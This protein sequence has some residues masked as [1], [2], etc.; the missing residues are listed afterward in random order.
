MKSDGY[1]KTSLKKRFLFSGFFANLY[2]FFAFHIYLLLSIL[3]AALSIAVILFFAEM[4][5]PKYV[6]LF[7]YSMSDKVFSELVADHKYHEAIA[8]MDTKKDMIEESDESYRYRQELADCYIHTGDYPKALEQYRLLRQEIDQKFKEEPP[9][10][11]TQ[12]QLKNFKD[13]IDACFLKEEFRIYLKMG[14]LPNIRK[15][16]GLIT[17]RYKDVDWDNLF[18]Y[19]SEE[20]QEKLSQAL[21]GRSFE[22]GFQLELIQGKYLTDPTAGIEQMEKYAIDVANSKDFNQVYKLRLFNELL[23][24][25]LEQNDTI[26]ARYYLEYALQIVDS[27]EYNS[28]IYPQLGE[29]SDYC[30]QL[31]DIADGK[32]LL[33]KYLSYVDDT[34]DESDI[35][36][37]LAHA[38]EFKYLQ[39]EGNWEELSERAD[40]TSKSLRE[41]I[42]R[43]FTGMTSSQREFFVKQFMPVFD[44]VNNLVELKHDDKL[45]TV[46]FDNNMFLRGLLLRSESVLGNAIAAMNDKDLLDK[47]IRY[48]AASKELV[49]RQYVSGPGN[50]FKKQQ[51]EKEIEELETELATKSMEFRRDNADKVLSASHLR[52]S[53]DKNDVVIQIVEGNKT[54]YALALDNSGTV[55]YAAIGDKATVNQLLNDRIN[56]YTDHNSTNQL[57][58]SILPIING[59][60]I[61]LTSTGAFNKMSL[62]GMP[63]EAN[64]KTLGDIANVHLVISPTEI[65]NVKARNSSMNLVA[66]NAVLWGGIKYGSANDTIENYVSQDTVIPDSNILRGE[67]LRYLPGSLREVTDIANLLQNHNNK[68]TLITADKATEKSLTNRSGQKDYILHISTHGFFHDTEA[69]ENPMQ[70]SGLLFANSQ[71]YWMNDSI[72]STINESDGILRAD[73]IANLDLN[74]CRLVVLSACQTGLGMSDTEGVYGLQRAFKLAGAESILMSLWSVDDAA[75]KVL[76][77]QFYTG[78]LNGQT[79]DDALTY[80]KNQMRRSGYSPD[81]WAAFVLLN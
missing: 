27:L 23:R 18:N 72:A 3:G 29:L 62:S 12:K 19:F 37:A 74:G 75:T 34:Y 11:L 26:S 22:D 50:Y 76:M 8:F 41:Q 81:K 71:R 53:L 66:K 51:L 14:D 79:P 36:Y 1:D 39:A 4:L 21:N 49:S 13:M 47:Y 35:D 9:E 17:D 77:T 73:E 68:A 10:D 20:Q 30:Y 64:G 31:N 15:Y 70:N 58:A 57:L 38:K 78:L 56:V 24:M 67:E 25:L 42:S 28:V 46:A 48:V 69:F 5:F 16:S 2:Y 55:K 63:I 52:K 60:D 59:K 80:A 33:K 40:E 54:Y 45:A 61:Y 65:P 32:R 44:Y 6:H 43:N 7:N